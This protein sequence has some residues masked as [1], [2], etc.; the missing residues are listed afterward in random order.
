[1]AS[2]MVTAPGLTGGS[3][4]F[5]ARAMAMGMPK[6][7]Q[8]PPSR[9]EGQFT[10]TTD[11]EILTNNSEDG[12][13]AAPP[14]SRSTGTSGRDS[15]ASPK[16]WSGFR[17]GQRLRPALQFVANLGQQVDFARPGRGSAGFFT[18][19]LAQR[20]SRKMMNARIRKLSATVRNWPQPST[21]TPAFLSSA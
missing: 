9:A 18:I 1:M 14:A 4:P 13:A 19:W 17:A 20:T 5:G 2:V 21:A 12:P 6:P 7:D 10:I 11:G 16:C 3:G 8:G 15:S